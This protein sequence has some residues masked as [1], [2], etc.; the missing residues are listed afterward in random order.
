M[1]RV[2]I[3]GIS[4]EKDL[5][6]AINEGYHAIGSVINV[7]NSPRNIST[8]KASM[9]FDKI[10]P[11]ITSVAVIVPNSIND[12]KLIEEVVHPDIIQI[13]GLFEEAFLKMSEMKF[14]LN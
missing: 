6:L 12:I 7:K 13:H 9:L 1:V 14:Q 3:C 2:K 8:Q 5:K 10:P 11:F 4:N